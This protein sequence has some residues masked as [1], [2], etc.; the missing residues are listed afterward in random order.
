MKQ[1]VKTKVYCTFAGADMLLNLTDVLTSEG[2]SRTED[3]EIAL[4]VFESRMGSFPITEKTPLRLELENAGAG[5]ARLKGHA[6]I[7]QRMNCDRCL[8]ETPVTIVLDFEREV[9]SP[10]ITDAAVSDDTDGGVMEGY[11][12]NVEALV[13]NELLMNQP[14]RV[15]CRPDCR[16]ICKKC[17]RDLNE[18]ECGCD[19]FVPDPRMAVLK[20]IFN[21][22][23]EV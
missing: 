8:K 9:Y 21:A 18:G 15:L 5:R 14:E 20:D 19:T 2:K 16:G 10:E 22:S 6:V 12:L 11:Q 3:A 17:G 7:T 13:Y 23:K 1:C 4:T